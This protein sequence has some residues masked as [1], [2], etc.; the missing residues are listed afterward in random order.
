M[1]ATRRT[2][3]RRRSQKPDRYSY[4]LTAAGAWTSPAPRVAIASAPVITKNVK[5]M[6]IKK[7]VRIK[8]EKWDFT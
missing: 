5:R 6:V 4:D 2:K 7:E 1:K 3:N 8:E